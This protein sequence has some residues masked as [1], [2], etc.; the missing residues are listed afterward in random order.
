M[1]ILSAEGTFGNPGMVITSPQITTMN[2]APAARRTSR[3]LTVWP[4]GA[5]RAPGSVEKEY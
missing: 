3:T 1:S 5:P 4:L 2:S